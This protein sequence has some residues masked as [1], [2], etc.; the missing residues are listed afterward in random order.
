[1]KTAIEEG[2]RNFYDDLN[3]NHHFLV[4]VQSTYL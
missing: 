2:D 1:V 4:L 3:V